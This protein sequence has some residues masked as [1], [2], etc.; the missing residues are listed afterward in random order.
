[1]DTGMSTLQA[2]LFLMVIVT[3]PLQALAVSL[4]YRL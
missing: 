1:M 3:I 4:A 2:T